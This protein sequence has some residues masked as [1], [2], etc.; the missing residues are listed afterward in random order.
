MSAVYKAVGESPSLPSLH[1]AP[2]QVNDLPD[3]LA[4]ENDVYPY[5]WTRG[6][7]LDSLYSGYETWV[8]RDASGV[9]VGYFLLMLAVDEAH[10]LNISVRRDLHGRG[11]GRMQLDK[12]VAVAREKGMSSVLL[13]VRPS[14]QRALSVYQHYGFVQIGQRKGYYPA[15][16][17]TRED[18]IVMRF[19]L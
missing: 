13:E 14:N 2:M 8:L 16:G 19:Q 11:I 3:V 12:V 5:P 6:N 18:A 10:L 15:Q 1:F 17:N 7:F 9:L 4:I